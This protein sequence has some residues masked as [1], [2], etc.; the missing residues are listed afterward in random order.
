M[1]ATLAIWRAHAISARNALR[2]DRRMQ[3]ALGMGLFVGLALSWWGSSRLY[4]AIQSWH[5]QGGQATTGGLW[6][7][8]LGIWLGMGLLSIPTA[9]SMLSNDEAVLLLTL[10]LPPATRFRTLIGSLFLNNVPIG[11][12][13]ILVTGYVLVSSLGWYGLLW[14]VILQSGAI[15]AVACFQVITFFIVRGVF[16]PRHRWPAI[17]ASLAAV[18]LCYVLAVASPS[19]VE[20]WIRPELIGICL[21]LLLIAMLGPG[22]TSPGRLYVATCYA[23]QNR[24]RALS[25]FV[26]PGAWALRRLS[27]RQ[28]NLEGALYAKALAI[29]GRNLFFWGRL[30]VAYVLLAL[31][32]LLRGAL[33][34]YGFSLTVLVGDYAALLPVI[35][36]IETAPNAISGEAACLAFYITA[37]LRP[38]QVLRAKLLV[39]L[40]PVLGE[41]FVMGIILSWLN[42]LSL[43]QAGDALLLV[44]LIIPGA[45]CLLVWGSAWDADLNRNVEGATE[46]LLQE[47][48]PFSPR[49]MLLFQI[50]L[51]YLAVTILLCWK[52]PFA[53]A[54]SA[55]LG[56]DAVIML[57]MWRLGLYWWNQLVVRG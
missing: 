55:L 24:D 3:V 2:Y 15:V 34:H 18:A 50:S 57:G 47:E 4:V 43:L 22:A 8:C 48:G 46:R 11:V 49:R 54:I 20:N 23:V 28:R 45:L 13:Q 35:H 33:N 21:L 29:Q 27:E 30:V 40:L 56:L 41:G 39:F 53:L 16:S 7:L 44:L 26:F 38:S 52:L 1:N 6:L 42:R 31:F 32:P 9:W 14:L 37:P 51:C 12:L 19:A 36:V 10:P 25:A 5:H 17:G